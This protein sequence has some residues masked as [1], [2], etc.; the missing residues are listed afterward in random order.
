MVTRLEVAPVAVEAFIFQPPMSTGAAAGLYS[1]TNSSLAPLGPRVRNSLMSTAGSGVT[2]VGVLVGVIVG[3]SVGAA[4]GLVGEAL[5][6]GAG[7]TA[8]KSAELLSVSVH[9][10]PARIAAVVVL[11]AWAGLPSEQ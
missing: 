7:T 11:S 9:P 2:L 3:V 8:L 10:P 6:R 4:Q 1:S 5:L